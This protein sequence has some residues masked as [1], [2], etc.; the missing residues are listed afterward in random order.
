MGTIA[1]KLAYLSDAVD[2]IQD[3][4][5]EKGVVVNDTVALGDYGDKIRAIPSGGSGNTFMDMFGARTYS[6][7]TL[8]PITK[9]YTSL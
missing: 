9:T 5:N 2:D 1:E 3:A 7:T 6:E 8:T 4:I